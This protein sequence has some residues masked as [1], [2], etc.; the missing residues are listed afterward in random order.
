MNKENRKPAAGGNTRR[1]IAMGAGA[2]LGGAAGI[3]GAALFTSQEAE[4]APVESH[5]EDDNT[6][7]SAD[8]QVMEARPEPDYADEPKVMAVEEPEPDDNDNDVEILGYERVDMGDGELAD[9]A[10]LNVDGHAAVIMDANLNGE[11]DYI[12]V[13]YNDNGVFEDSEGRIVTGEGMEMQPLHQ[14]YAEQ[15]P[16]EFTPGDDD[17]PADP[18]EDIYNPDDDPNLLAEGD[19]DDFVNDADVSD[20]DTMLT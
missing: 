6:Y 16:E 20:F 13:D 17:V 14:M 12:A 10:V 7:E 2:A 15:H 8:V 3:G 5:D 19:M 9:I 4:A 1:N 18:G 11:A